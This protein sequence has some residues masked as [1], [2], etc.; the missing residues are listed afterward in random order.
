MCRL[1]GA[2]ENANVV[3]H[4]GSNLVKN[5]LDKV[6][7]IS[8]AAPDLIKAAQDPAQAAD[9]QKRFDSFKRGMGSKHMRKFNRM[10]DMKPSADFK[11]AAEKLPPLISKVKTNHCHY[12]EMYAPNLEDL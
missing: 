12:D 3:A 5:D 4:V 8:D 10:Y 2:N 1:G 7:S 11:D 6:L 9:R